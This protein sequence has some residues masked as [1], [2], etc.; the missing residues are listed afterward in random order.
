MVT[1]IKM[2]APEFL[3]GRDPL[4]REAI[5]QDL[6]HAFRHTD[7]LGVGPI[8]IALWDLAG[9][10]YDESI[11][12]LLGGSG[13]QVSAYAST[14]HPDYSDDGLNSPAAFAEFARQCRK[15]GYKAFKIHPYG[16]PQQDIEICRAVAE[17]VGDEM[18]LMLDPASEYQ[19]YA[20]TVEVGHVLDD[21]DFFWYEDP[22]AD[23]GQSVHMGR[24]LKNK[25]RTPLLGVEHSRTGPFGRVNHLEGEALELVRGDA[26]MDG[27]IT[28]VMKIANIAEAFGSDTELHVGGPAH[29][30]CMSAIRNTNYFEHGLKHPKVGWMADQGFQGQVEQVE[31][32]NITV[33]NGP[34]LG[35]D[36]D[37][38]FVSNRTQ[39]QTLIDE[40]G[41]S[42]VT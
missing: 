40:Q 8:D 4:E 23:T 21:L 7:H 15:D 30:H 2:A 39:T 1:Q 17:E 27:G 28:G 29:L 24:Q 26:H 41:S 6:W 35:V 3:I 11:S 33:P 5:W 32:G 18:D 12:K 37:W 14:Y 22:M 9:K 36:I 19:T 16:D 13:D 34:G 25:L 38:A 31:N 20:E 42:G 10:Y